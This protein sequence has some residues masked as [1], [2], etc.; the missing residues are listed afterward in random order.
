MPTEE[1]KQIQGY[2]GRYEVSNHGRVKSFTRGHVIILI[3]SVHYKGHLTVYLHKDSVR[4]KY[5]IHRLVAFA[6]IPNSDN[7]RLVN[8][9][10]CIKSNNLVT[11]LEWSTDSE[12]TQ[13]YYDHRNNTVDDIPF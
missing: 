11:N 4:K 13:Y 1:W 3:P 5:Y 10:D 2:E 7:K 9:K 12:N 6:F 8:H